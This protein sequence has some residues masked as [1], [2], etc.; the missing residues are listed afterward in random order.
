MIWLLAC[1]GSLRGGLPD[2]AEPTS[3]ERP[4]DV[5]V[6][7][8]GPDIVTGPGG[9]DT[10][11]RPPLLCAMELSCSQDIP[12]EPEVPCWFTVTSGY[13][14][15]EYEGWAGVETRGRSSANAP[16]HQYGVELWQDEAVRRWS[17]G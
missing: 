7:D 16:K 13:G 9:G 3:T 15:L 17:S 14:E 2:S 10:G 12:D 6:P 4:D 5:E 8:T 1:E 11:E